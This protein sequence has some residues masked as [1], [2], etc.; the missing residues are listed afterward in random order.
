MGGVVFC[1]VYVVCCVVRIRVVLWLWYILFVVMLSEL[2]TRIVSAVINYMWCELAF[3]N[4]YPCY[5][6]SFNFFIKCLAFIRIWTHSFLIILTYIIININSKTVEIQ[7]ISTL[8]EIISLFDYL[9]H[10]TIVCK[11][12]A[13]QCIL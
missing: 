4:S 12:M 10:V 5:Y 1:H 13:L 8:S 11:C 9:F 2:T 3:L 6:L 7:F